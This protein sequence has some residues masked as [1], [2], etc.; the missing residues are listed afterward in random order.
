MLFYVGTYTRLGGPG[1]AVCSLDS[2][3]ALLNA[4]ALPNP[5]YVIISEGNQK[6]Y[7]V[8]SDAVGQAEG[9]SYAAYAIDGDGLLETQRYNTGAGGPCHVCL[10]PDQRFLYTANYASGTLTVFP[11]DPPDERVQ[12]IHH[13][14][15]S[16]HPTR[17]DSPHVHHVSFVPD[18]NI[19]AAVDLGLDVVVFYEQDRQTGRLA[20]KSRLSCP[21]GMGPRHLVYGRDGIA[22]LVHELG[23]A[24]S[25]LQRTDSGYRIIQTV[26]TLPEG[27]SGDNTC[28]AIRT[29]GHHVFASNR[30]HDS[31]AVYRISAGGLLNPVGI[32]PTG[33]QT[34]RDFYLLPD[35]QVIVGHQGGSVT[36]LNWDS[37]SEL[38][39]PSGLSLAL[40]GAVCICPVIL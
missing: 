19:L 37:R 22:W 16:I 4:V 38:L 34:P 9:G 7:A 5:T 6:L 18:S 12:L 36:L 39:Q 11:L 13:Q 20:E 2:E 3:L 35:G 10:S 15:S 21:A 14:G 33:G 23:N 32:F 30:G 31:I 29:D 25:T 28:A 26:T 17:Q 24:V 8:S 27:W 1:I 40:P